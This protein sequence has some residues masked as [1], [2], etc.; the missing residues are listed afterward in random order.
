[1]NWVFWF[2]II[3]VLAFVWATF[4]GVWTKL[5]NWLEN[6]KNNMKEAVKENENERK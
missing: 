4:T 1:M 5:G 3:L 2:L 6:T